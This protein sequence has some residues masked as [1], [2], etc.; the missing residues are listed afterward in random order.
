MNPRTEHVMRQWTLAQPVV[1]SYLTALVRDFAARDDL[2]QDVAVAVLESVDRY[3][4]S[5]PFVGWAIGIARNSVRQYYRTSGREPLVFD[6]ELTGQLAVTF[7]RVSSDQLQRLD[8]LQDCLPRLDGRAQA[9]C[10]LRYTDGLKPAAIARA[11]GMRANS[12][13]KALQRIRQQLREC[14][15]S[16][17]SQLEVGR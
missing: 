16:K 6:A 9:I 14:I 17:A 12:V 13:S 7:E 4:P 5:R 8:F 1:S 10:S 11:L 15:D 2:L 3:D